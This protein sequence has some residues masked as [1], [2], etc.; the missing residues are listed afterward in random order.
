MSER[1]RPCWP[2]GRRRRETECVRHPPYPPISSLSA[3]SPV[4]PVSVLPAGCAVCAPSMPASLSATAVL[5]LELEQQPFEF[6]QQLCELEQQF[7]PVHRTAWAAQQYL[8]SYFDRASARPGRSTIHPRNRPTDDCQQTRRFHRAR[9][10][11]RYSR[12]QSDQPAPYRALLYELR[13]K[14]GNNAGQVSG[15][16]PNWFGVAMSDPE[17]F[18]LSK[19]VYVVIY[20]HPTP[21]QVHYRDQDYPTKTGTAGGTDWKQLYAYV[22]RLG[23]QMAGAVEAGAPANRLVVFRS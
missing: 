22:D 11:R 20:F 19:N 5:K 23:G 2:G 21:R 9:T 6:E 17:T 10:V 15:V 1:D 16:V 14:I 7:D 8:P 4:S 18:D 12:F 13:D 3:V